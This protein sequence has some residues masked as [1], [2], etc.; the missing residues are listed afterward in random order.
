MY[1]LS[2]NSISKYDLLNLI[3]DV[4]K[5]EIKIINDKKIK[6]NKSLNSNLLKKL[7]G[8]RVKNWKKLIKEM[9]EFNKKN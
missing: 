2:G 6:I 1:H 7:T 3:K 4:Y 9:F 5:K 8:Y